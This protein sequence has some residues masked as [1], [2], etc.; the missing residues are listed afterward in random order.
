MQFNP[1]YTITGRLL[2]N[3]SRINV[4]VNELNNRRFP[5]LILVEFEKSAQAVSVFASTSIEGNPLPLTEVKKI[6]KSKPEYI[7]DSEREVLNYNHA[8]GYLC[9]LLE[10]EKLRL[11]IELI[12]KV[13]KQ[14]VEGLLPEFELGR[15]RERAVVVNDPKHR[16]VVYLPPDFN[17][18]KTLME[19]LI[20]YIDKNAGKIDPLILAG[21]FHKQMVIIHPFMDGNGRVTR[22]TTKVLLAA[23]G[24]DTFNLFSFENYYNKNVTLYFKTVG[25]FGNYYELVDK[26]NFTFWLEYFTEGIIDELLRVQKQLGRAEM[27][28]ETELQSYHHKIMEFIQ[29]KGF[30]ADR[31]YVSLTKR[32]KPTRALD[33]KKLID[34]GLI[35]KKGKA[36]ATYYI[37]RDKK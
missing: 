25:E 18:V 31:D 15:L 2:A 26:I 29:E 9:S 33:F 20:A 36:R 5:H 8:L 34:L 37:L 7:R 1:S 32:A 16:K 19:D 6:L 35:V 28:P 27:T 21:I 30:I 12:L 11:S 22:L 24:L 14:V 23:M 4:L 13:Q 17:D 10:K 3:I